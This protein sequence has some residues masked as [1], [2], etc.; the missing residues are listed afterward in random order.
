ML[1][2]TF[3]HVPRIGATKERSL[4]R[5]GYLDWRDVLDGPRPGAWSPERWDDLRAHLDQSEEALAARDAL[6]FEKGMHAAET[7][8]LYDQFGARAAFV[9]IETTGYGGMHSP[10]TVVGAVVS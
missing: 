7:W 1:R 3:I 10:I 9:D 2:A 6:F 5:R 4:W 8:R